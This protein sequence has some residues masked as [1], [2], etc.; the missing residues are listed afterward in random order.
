[1]ISPSKGHCQTSLA[2]VTAEFQDI[3]QLKKIKCV[4]TN[5]VTGKSTQSS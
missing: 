5:I 3:H 4:N 1:L 2:G